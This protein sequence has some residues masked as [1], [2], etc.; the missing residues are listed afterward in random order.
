MTKIVHPRLTLEQL[1]EQTC[2]RELPPKQK[3][4]VDVFIQNGGNKTEAVLAAY[5]VKSKENARVLSYAVFGSPTVIACLAAYFQDDPLASFTRAC[6]A[7]Y[8][9]KKL[10]GAQVQALALIAK[11]NGW[12]SAALPTEML[13][14]RD[15]EPEESQAPVEP[16]PTTRVP[17]GA[18]PLVDDQGIVRGY[19]T[20]AGDYVQLADVEAQ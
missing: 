17:A 13:H 16:I 12:G 19:K 3:K 5:K 4:A 18:T 20:E 15:A 8:R 7:A 2:Y 14:G 10:T 11:I 1:H 9:R 6:Y